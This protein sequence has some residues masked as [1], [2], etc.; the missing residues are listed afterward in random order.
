MQTRGGAR[1]VNT[2]SQLDFSSFRDA[3]TVPR[4]YIVRARACHGAGA[5]V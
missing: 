1:D 2:R 4:A 3:V 5:C